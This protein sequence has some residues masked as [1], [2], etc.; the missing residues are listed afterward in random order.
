MDTS[1]FQ[2]TLH[3]KEDKVIVN[4]SKFD[5]CLDIINQLR[6]VNY[7]A[8]GCLDMYGNNLKSFDWYTH[9]ADMKK[10]SKKHPKII[11]RLYVQDLEENKQFHKYF[12][13]G[14][15]QVCELVCYFP[16]FNEKELK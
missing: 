14:K 2:L 13:N 7:E 9:E 12:K 1:R 4:I 3:K 8:G 5:K 11:F 10:F 16:E 15:M 6:L